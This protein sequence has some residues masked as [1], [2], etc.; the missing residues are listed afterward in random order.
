MDRET[1][2]KELARAQISVVSIIIKVFVGALALIAALSSFTVVEPGHVG[3]V[4][5]AGSVQKT[6]LSEGFHFKAPFI[7]SVYEMNARMQSVKAKAG[8]SSKDL[9][10][11][12]A[13]VEVQF[14]ITGGMAPMVYKKFGTSEALGK[15]VLAPAVQETVKAVTSRYTAEELITQRPAAKAALEEKLREFVDKTLGKK[16]L[17]GALDIANVALTDFDFSPE[18]NA[19]IEAKVKAE[20]KALKAV[21]EKRERITNAEAKAEEQKLAADA[22]AYKIAQESEARAKA[23]EVEAEA[24]RNQ[25]DLIELRRIEAW[26]GKLPHYNGGGAIPMLPLK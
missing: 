9:Q 22:L 24:L 5:R 8:S 20:Q 2:R 16:N 26:D 21:N 11:V 17:R 18:F 7:D 6:A 25:P 4:R 12:S 13:V 15:V 3:V 14:S 1:A 19:S 10:V 23:I